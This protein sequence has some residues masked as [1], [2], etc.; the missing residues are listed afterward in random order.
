[1]RMIDVITLRDTTTASD[2]NGAATLTNADKLVYA[3]IQSVK[4]QEFY[5]AQAAGVRADILF[6]VNEDE[7]SGEMTVLYDSVAYKVSRMYTDKGRVELTCT[8]R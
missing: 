8:R 5:A 3:D 7:Y 2:A 1:M 4:R 6:R